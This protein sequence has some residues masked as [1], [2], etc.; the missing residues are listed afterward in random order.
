[1]A[2]IERLFRIISEAPLHANEP[3]LD[4]RFTVISVLIGFLKLDLDG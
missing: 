2:P 3:K 4:G 1:M